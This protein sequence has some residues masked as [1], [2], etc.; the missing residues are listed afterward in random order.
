M[1]THNWL[2]IRYRD[3]YDVPRLIVIELDT[4]IFVLDCPFDETLDEYPDQY[5]VYRLPL[6]AKVKLNDLADWRPVLSG[7][8][9]LGSVRLDAV[10]FDESKRKYVDA[11][12]LAPFVGE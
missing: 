3:F 1:R 6:D 4:A 12:V 11:G 9:S 7:L 8:T 5:L 10:R 2:P